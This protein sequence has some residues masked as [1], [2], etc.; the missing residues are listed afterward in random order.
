M[1]ELR[2]E[3]SQGHG[4]PYVVWDLAPLSPLLVT[5]LFSPN[6]RNMGS[7]CHKNSQE[8]LLLFLFS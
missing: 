4:L 6:G 7:V 3:H 5:F 8:K 2:R 1:A